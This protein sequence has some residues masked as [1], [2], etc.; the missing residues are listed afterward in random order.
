MCAQANKQWTAEYAHIIIRAI[1]CV[2]SQ[3]IELFDKR[4]PWNIKQV[5]Y[6]IRWKL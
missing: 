4:G 2:I 5:I 1:E 6:A 3:Q